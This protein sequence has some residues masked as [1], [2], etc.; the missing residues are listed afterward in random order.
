LNLKPSGMDET[1][2]VGFN[3]VT[4]TEASQVENNKMKVKKMKYKLITF[5]ILGL[6]LI[7]GA[8]IITYLGLFY[9][10]TTQSTTQIFHMVLHDKSVKDNAI[11]LDLTVDP[12]EQLEYSRSPQE[13][14]DAHSKEILGLK[15]FKRGII[16]Y[17]EENGDKCFI[18]KIV[19][20]SALH[21][22]A[23]GT[24]QEAEVDDDKIQ[25]YFYLNQTIHPFVLRLA[26]GGKI[27]EFCGTADAIWMIPTDEED[28]TDAPGEISDANTSEDVS[29]VIASE[30][31]SRVKRWG[32]GWGGGSYYRRCWWNCSWWGWKKV[33]TQRCAY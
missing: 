1:D 28:Y 19:P 29:E 13:G 21:S 8:I 10:K 6:G 25:T 14:V 26:A 20:Y 17:K 3:G 24:F 16:A 15:D 9:W 32:W 22:L 31:K 11:R 2:S 7:V 5:I 4:V 18:G 27:V 33:C 23:N 12:T 30:E